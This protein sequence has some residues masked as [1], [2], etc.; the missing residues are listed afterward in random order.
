MGIWT[1]FRQTWLITRVCIH[2]NKTQV[3]TNIINKNKKTACSVIYIYQNLCKLLIWSN[4]CILIYFQRHIRLQRT[5]IKMRRRKK[6]Q[7]LNIT[8]TCTYT[9]IHTHKQ[10]TYA[11]TQT[12]TNC[13]T[14]H[15]QQH[16]FV[17][18]QCVHSQHVLCWQGQRTPQ[19]MLLACTMSATCIN[20]QHS[21]RTKQICN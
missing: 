6:D 1:N 15:S 20:I 8:E 21:F 4:L 2:H 14:S 7:S 3:T 18:V 16:R 19:C 17:R 10:R 5:T 13:Q 11:H 9:H 12:H